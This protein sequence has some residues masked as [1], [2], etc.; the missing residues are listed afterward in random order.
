MALPA[1][2]I[3]FAAVLSERLAV[4]DVPAYLSGT[5]YPDSRWLTG[6]DR[7]QTHDRRFLDPRFPADDFSLG[8][9]I[10]CAADCIQADMHASLLPDLAE[11][12]PDDRW[13]RVSA[14]KAIQDRSD[15]AGGKLDGV[16]PCLN[17]TRTPN[18]ES[19]Q[20]VAAYLDLVRRVYSRGAAP[21]WS[22]YAELWTGVGLGRQKIERIEDQMNRIHADEGLVNRLQESFDRMVHRYVRSD[23]MMS[24]IKHGSRGSQ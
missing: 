1:T 9:H 23:V 6:V 11:L 18:G 8:W 17:D 24:V 5:L 12:A 13:I 10:H 20:G 2:H 19:A 14:A 15:A 16:L 21:E 4:T 7:E 22:D 3:R